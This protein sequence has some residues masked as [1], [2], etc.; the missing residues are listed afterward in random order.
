MGVNLGQTIAN[1]RKQMQITQEDLAESIGV[2]A[3]SISKWETGATY[4][5]ILL[6]PVIADTF[7]VSLDTLFG[8]RGKD[9]VDG[10]IFAS[11]DEVFL[12]TLYSYFTGGNDDKYEKDGRNKF[13]DSLRSDNRLNSAVIQRNKGMLLYNSKIGAAT[14]KCPKGGWVSL[15]DDYGTTLQPLF[16]RLADTGFA[17]LLQ[18][19]LGKENYSF[20]VNSVAKKTG[21]DLEAVK[22][23]LDYL[24]SE[25]I[26]GTNTLDLEEGEVTVYSVNAE[27]KLIPLFAMLTYAN[28]YGNFQSSYMCFQGDVRFYLP[29]VD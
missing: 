6:L 16:E 15:F 9:P 21:L 5:D 12:D 24:A 26:V 2:S 8:R 1:L 10:D 19:I 20:T 13:K 14:L 3:Q 25:Y 7:N 18:M 11:M 22:G 27:S 28:Y 29:E 4:P 23:H 17:S